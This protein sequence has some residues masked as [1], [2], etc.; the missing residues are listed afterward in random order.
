MPPSPASPG[1]SRAIGRVLAPRLL[2]LRERVVPE[3][4]PR[5]GYVLTADGAVVGIVLAIFAETDE[6]GTRANVSSWYVDAAYRGYSNMLLAAAFRAKNVTFLNISPS[7]ATIETIAAQGFACYVQGTFHAMAAL[8][9]R[10]P[11]ARVRTVA[12]GTHEAP[13]LSRRARCLRLHLPRGSSIAGDAYP[14]VF[15]PAR[16]GPATRLPSAQLVYC[17]GLAETWCGSPGRSAGISRGSASPP[18]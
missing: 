15:V 17:R 1:I 13:G 10:V 12:A 9:R 14:F 11:G 3:G 8:A 16:S 6:G 2:R 5:Y 18:S 4:R 7:P